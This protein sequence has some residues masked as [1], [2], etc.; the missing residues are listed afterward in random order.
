MREFFI[1]WA[2]KLIAV[3]IVLAGLGLLLGGLFA[4]FSGMPGGFLQGLLMIIFG[5]LYLIIIGGVMYI[6]FGI[7][8]NTQ[9]TNRLLEE[10]LKR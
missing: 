1:D 3:F 8:R 4:M 6:A 9:Q 2:E 7:Y 5:G 10:M